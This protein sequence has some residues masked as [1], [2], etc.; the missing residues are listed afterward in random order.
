MRRSHRAARRPLRRYTG[1]V[2]TQREPILRILLN[3]LFAACSLA[4]V[5]LALAQAY[6]AKPV[7]VIVPVPAGSGLD[8]VGRIATEKMAQNMGAVFVID[9]I[10]GAAANIG[11]AP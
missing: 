4:A 6:P 1:A 2:A 5:S 9:N 3:G 7:R 11:A 8:I 10:A